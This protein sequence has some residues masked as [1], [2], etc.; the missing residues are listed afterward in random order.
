MPYDPT[1]PDERERSFHY[2]FIWLGI[3]GT[4]FW[5]A[6]LFVGMDNMLSAI[7]Y[8]AMAGG[9]LSAGFG[10]RADEY[11]RSLCGMGMR[12]ACAALGVYLIALF[13][14][15]N[16]DVARNLGYWL[17]SG[18]MRQSTDP[19]QPAIF[20]SRIFAVGLAFMFYAGYVFAWARDRFGPAE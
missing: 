13:I 1:A 12:W 5:T 4:V 10:N 14:L 2:N 19:M 6:N 16:G 20:D 15:A 9:P 18:E 11:F 3:A 7:F 8:G 17:A